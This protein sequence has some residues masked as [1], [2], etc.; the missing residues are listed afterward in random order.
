MMLLCDKPAEG[1]LRELVADSRHEADE[2]AGF[3][4]AVR[5]IGQCIGDMNSIKRLAH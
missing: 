1:D 4:L 5:E 2:A 3:V